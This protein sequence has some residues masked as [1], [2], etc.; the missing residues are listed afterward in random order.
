MKY[1]LNH[2]GQFKAHILNE[3][4]TILA[5]A[6]KGKVWLIFTPNLKDLM[7]ESRL[8]KEIISVYLKWQSDQLISR[9]SH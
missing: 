8:K 3:S 4:G 2:E 9:A 6:I 5:T 7:G 1:T